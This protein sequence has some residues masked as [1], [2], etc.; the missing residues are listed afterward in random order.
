MPNPILHTTCAATDTKIAGLHAST[1]WKE[2]QGRL[3]EAQAPF[4][5]NRAS[6]YPSLPVVATKPQPPNQ[7][8]AIQDEYELLGQ[9]DNSSSWELFP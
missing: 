2:A 3:A 6:E 7:N 4:I 5:T 1:H 8:R 9:D